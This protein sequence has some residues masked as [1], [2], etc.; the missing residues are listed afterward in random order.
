MPWLTGPA[1]CLASLH[2]DTFLS[3]FKQLLSCLPGKSCPEA[4]D[5]PWRR[6]VL[7][8]PGAQP[9]PNTGRC[10]G[11]GRGDN[12]VEKAAMLRSAQELVWTSTELGRGPVWA[13]WAVLGLRT[14]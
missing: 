8:F 2:Q 5:G 14:L 13:P 1:L 11:V 3:P 9:V 7:P 10:V 12:W 4:A 6:L